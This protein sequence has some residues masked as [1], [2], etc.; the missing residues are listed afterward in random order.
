[1]LATLPNG[2]IDALRE[3]RWDDF[4]LIVRPHARSGNKALWAEIA[5]EH[6]VSF[7]LLDTLEGLNPTQRRAAIYSLLPAVGEMADLQLEEALRLL[8]FGTTLDDPSGIFISGQLSPHVLR[9]PELADEIGESLRAD[10]STEPI[11]HQ[12]WGASFFSQAPAQAAAF[13]AKLIGGGSH[14]VALL[15]ALLL[16]LPSNSTSVVPY[17]GAHEEKLA[18]LLHASRI[19]HGIQSWMALAAIADFSQTAWQLLQTGMDSDDPK[20]AIALSRFLFRLTSPEVSV[21]HTPLNEVVRK[22]LNTALRDADARREIDSSVASLMYQEVLCPSVVEELPAL[23]ERD[24]NVVK[25]FPSIF[26]ALSPQPDFAR[27]LSVA[28]LSKDSTVSALKG[29]ISL[30]TQ[31]RAPVALDDNLFAAASPEAWIGAVKRLLGLTHYGPVLCEFIALLSEPSAGAKGVRLASIAQMLNYAFQEYPNATAAFLAAK[32]P[33]IPKS[34]PVAA[35]YRS[36]Y[37]NVLSWQRVLARLPERKELWPKVSERNAFLA[38][39]ERF[40]REVTRSAMEKSVFRAITRVEFTAQGQKVASHASDG[41]ITVQ[42]MAS[43]SQAIEL[44]TS[45]VSDP[46]RGILLRNNLLRGV[47]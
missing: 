41:G 21:A 29:A 6:P 8:K 42:E 4:A 28:L 11:E 34:S 26:G 47:E 18:G 1:M 45:E 35:V 44:P 46:M 2:A 39:K 13:A 40:H 23:F 36:V 19:D 16:S 3:R 22:L 33:Q 9:R 43:M 32:V 24:A 17:L 25:L 10:D 30:C 14:D 31:G 37:A 15:I 5:A 27:V 12:I 38:I 7:N 20:P